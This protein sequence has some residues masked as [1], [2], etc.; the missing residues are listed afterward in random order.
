V[1]SRGR[2]RVAGVG[3]EGAFENKELKGYLKK[4]GTGC[5]HLAGA[6]GKRGGSPVALRGHWGDPSQAAKSEMQT[7]RRR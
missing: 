3:E 7:G 6:R 5:N 1:F 2:E 4:S